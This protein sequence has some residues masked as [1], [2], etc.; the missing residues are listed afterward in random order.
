MTKKKT[1]EQAIGQLENIVNELE[2]SEL[3]LEKAISKFESGIKFS[4]HCND[5]LDKAEKKITIL[6]QDAEGN[7]KEEPFENE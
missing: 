3:P 6:L 1:F 5:L 4:M 7:V 2:D